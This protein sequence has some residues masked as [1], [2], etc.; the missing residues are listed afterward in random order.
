MVDREARD[1]L[2]D[3]IDSYLDEQITAFEFDDQIRDLAPTTEDDLVD[4]SRRMLWYF[5]DDC[6]DHT[7]VLS[8]TEWDY[9][10]RILLLLRS[11][12]T[13][14][15][16][17]RRLWSWRQ[18]V[19]ALALICGYAAML[20]T[21]F[22]ERSYLIVAACGLVSVAISDVV[23]GPTGV[24]KEASALTPFQSISD[25]L[26]VRRSAP[27]FSKRQYPASLVGT[28]IRGSLLE[29][30]IRWP[31]VVPLWLPVSPLIL[32]Y[33][34]LPTKDDRLIVVP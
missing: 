30:M 20:A 18:G 1:R 6:K 11:D 32:A 4:E 31:F 8:K 33:Q 19:A 10:Q 23:R 7:V 14:C 21:G 28:S 5:Y 22:D 2:A 15:R 12:A 24:E 34:L 27:G 26:R 25:V 29:T 13:V 17:P 16:E 9:F 3:L